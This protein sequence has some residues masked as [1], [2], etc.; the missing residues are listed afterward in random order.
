V[1]VEV[2][3]GGD[4]LVRKAKAEENE[5]QSCR[6]SHSLKCIFRDLFFRDRKVANDGRGR[7]RFKRCVAGL[8]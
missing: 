4:K 2:E 7:F 1:S 3:F 8:A 6:E 5:Q